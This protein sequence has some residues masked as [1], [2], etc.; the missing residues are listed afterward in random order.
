MWVVIAICAWLFLRW[1]RRIDWTPYTQQAGADPPPEPD[2][3]QLAR[4]DALA[5]EY[6]ELL[7]LLE[8]Q[9]QALNAAYAEGSTKERAQIAGKMVSVQRSIAATS[10]KLAAIEQKQDKIAEG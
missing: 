10:A 4:L 1:L 3:A 5:D 9:K 6:G 8:R 2:A 7:V